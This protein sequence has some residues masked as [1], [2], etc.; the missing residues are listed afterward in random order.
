MKPV[1]ADKMLQRKDRF[2][3]RAVAIAQDGDGAAA[4]SRVRAP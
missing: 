2:N 4:S 3:A 1:D